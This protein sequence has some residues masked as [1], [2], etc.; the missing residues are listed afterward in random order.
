MTNIHVHV[1][2]DNGLYE[3]IFLFAIR[4][5]FALFLFCFHFTL[6]NYSHI[7]KMPPN[8]DAL[9]SMTAMTAHSFGALSH[10][11][12]IWHSVVGQSI[13]WFILIG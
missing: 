9:S 2:F 6:T 4:M 1:F 8:F 12:T 3:T 5:P 11:R 10:V 13:I 7:A